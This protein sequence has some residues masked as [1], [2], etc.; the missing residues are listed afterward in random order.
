MILFK[1]ITKKYRTKKILNDITLEIDKGTLVALIGESG[2]GKTTLLKMLNRLIKPTSGDIFIN[3]ENIKNINEINLRRNMGYVIQNTGLFPHMTIKE[4]IELIPKIEKKEKAEIEEQTIKLMQM[5]G[6][7]PEDFLD[8]Y[9]S[10]LSGGQQQRIGIARAFAMDPEIVLMD[11]PFSALD[12]MTRSDLQDQIMSLQAKWKKTIVFVTHNM[13]EAIKIADKICIMRNG[14]IL[15]YDTPETILKYPVDD[16]VAN[17]VGKNRIWSSPEYIKIEDI[18]IESPVTAIDSLSVSKCMDK[19][20]KNRVDSLLLLENETKKLIGIVTAKKLRTIEERTKEA[21]Q[22]M[23]SNFPILYP[24]QC[25]LDALK[26]VKEENVSRIP[27]VDQDG[28]LK[29]L[30]TKGSLVTALSEQY[31]DVEEE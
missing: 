19:M 28:Y 26:M 16:Y 9:P 24:D 5:V 15:Q 22:Y 29:G 12:P 7:V 2:C 27:V 8:R 25:I 23:Q 1:N 3:N 18:M 14:N 30:I 6:L 20:K 11:E 4:N 17:F 13:D 31:F 10:E 21:K